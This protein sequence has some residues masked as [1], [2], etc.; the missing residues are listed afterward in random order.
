MGKDISIDAT[1]IVESASPATFV[2]Y[3]KEITP[4]GPS[5]KNR[6]ES[7]RNGQKMSS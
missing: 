7:F 5:G 2:A 4:G 1:Q 3:M 6:I